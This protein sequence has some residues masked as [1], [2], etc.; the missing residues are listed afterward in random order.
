MKP[1]ND[2]IEITY[3]YEDGS[4]GAWST[5]MRERF[6]EVGGVVGGDETYALARARVE[7]AVRW[8]LDR[9][10]ARFASFIDEASIPAYLAEKERAATAAAANTA[11]AA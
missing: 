10:E 5:D 11:N 4:W 8:V 2:P 6:P 3:H 1:T 9:P 7:D